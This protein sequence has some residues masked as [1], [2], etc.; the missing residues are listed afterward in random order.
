MYSVVIVGSASFPSHKTVVAAEQ[1]HVVGQEGVV[2]YSV[3]VSVRGRENRGEKI[4][5]QWL[6]SWLLHNMSSSDRSSQCSPDLHTI[7]TLV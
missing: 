7:H 1:S 3:V 2:G 4:N 6:L 5:F